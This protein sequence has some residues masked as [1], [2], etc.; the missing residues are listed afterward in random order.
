MSDFHPITFHSV[1]GVPLGELMATREMCEV[2][3][4][5]TGSGCGARL[6]SGD[7]RLHIQALPQPKHETQQ[8]HVTAE[9]FE[10]APMPAGHAMEAWAAYF[11]YYGDISPE[12]RALF[13]ET[14]K[15][16]NDYLKLWG[17]VVIAHPKD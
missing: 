1:N 8:C 11:T 4:H 5:Y 13:I 16:F 15:L 12:E 9:S 2:L 7:G 17:A 6:W 10:P 14:A 3:G